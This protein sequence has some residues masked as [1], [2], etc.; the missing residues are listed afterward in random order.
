[1]L[2]LQTCV[3]TLF[4]F[5]WA[6]QSAKHRAAVC[7]RLQEVD[8]TGACLRTTMLHGNFCMHLLL[9]GAAQLPLHTAIEVADRL[10]ERFSPQP[11]LEWLWTGPNADVLA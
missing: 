4:P 10:T 2:D 8:H 3:F 1:M 7:E 6:V 5:S 9:A 11:L